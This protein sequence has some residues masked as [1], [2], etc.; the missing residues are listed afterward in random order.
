VAVRVETK[1]LTIIIQEHQV[2]LVAADREET[3]QVDPADQEQ[4]GK[5]IQAGQAAV[6]E[7]I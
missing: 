4:V 3:L 5:E 6:M 7:S 1:G 2:G